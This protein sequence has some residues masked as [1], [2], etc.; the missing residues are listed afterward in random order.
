MG[1][2]DRRGSLT[3]LDEMDQY[4]LEYWRSRTED[5]LVF[6]DK[7]QFQSLK[8][9][10]SEFD[11]VYQPFRSIEHEA[12]RLKST[13]KSTPY[14]SIDVTSLEQS[15]KQIWNDV[16]YSKQILEASIYAVHRLEGMK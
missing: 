10:L 8:K 12:E 11:E 7:T 9:Q 14:Q 5:Y 15:V 16:L 6:F 3:I 2:Y 13:L 1:M 4:L